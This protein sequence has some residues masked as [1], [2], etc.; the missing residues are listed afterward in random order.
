MDSENGKNE[1]PEGGSFDSP[2]CPQGQQGGGEEQGCGC[3]ASGASGG[4]GTAKLR[5]I[6]FTVIIVAAVAV[7]AW[8]L[9]KGNKDDE[10]MQL[11]E[12]LG[13]GEMLTRPD[14]AS[15]PDELVSLAAYTLD[16]VAPDKDFAFVLLAGGEG[17][18]MSEELQAIGQAS[19]T[20]AGRGI[21]IAAITLPTDD[22][23]HIKMADALDIDSFPVVVLL[24]KG[25]PPSVVTGDITENAL[26][27]A[28][29][30]SACEPGCGPASC[31]PSQSS[32][33]GQ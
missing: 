2:C 4:S 18:A 5:H 27:R 29:V 10:V 7:A 24:G 6:I 3:S 1:T 13:T 15:E 17:R 33:P 8:A 20:L 32:G 25:C 31:G 23:D 26:L 21:E 16:S 11:E 14:E 22:P 28:Y 12:A 9:L 30:L 19:E